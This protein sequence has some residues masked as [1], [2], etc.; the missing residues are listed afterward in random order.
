MVIENEHLSG[1]EFNTGTHFDWRRGRTDEEITI[2][3]PQEIKDRSDVSKRCRA[4]KTEYVESGIDEGVAQSMA[5]LNDEQLGPILANMSLVQNELTR[6]HDVFTTYR[7]S[8]GA[9]RGRIEELRPER[10]RRAILKEAIAKKI[11]SGSQLTVEDYDS[12]TY[13]NY[14]DFERKIMA[15]D[16]WHFLC[17]G[18]LDELSKLPYIYSVPK[19]DQ[20]KVFRSMF[21]DLIKEG[22]EN[23][24]K[25]SENK[26]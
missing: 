1:D 13:P 24:R 12:K 7:T 22:L 20:Q 11:L 23:Y 15:S 3:T 9:T 19:E 26:V 4:R 17:Q 25:D 10:E 14:G 21:E 6:K 16:I 2:K 8:I 18:Q 5:F